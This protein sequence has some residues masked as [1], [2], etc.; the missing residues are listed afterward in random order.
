MP[1]YKYKLTSMNNSSTKFGPCD[2]CN[3][4][5]MEVFRQSKSEKHKSEFHGSTFWTFISDLFGH[6][7]C[8]KRGRV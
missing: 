2:V 5:A 4:H 1:T 6:E 8:L 7:E 3:K